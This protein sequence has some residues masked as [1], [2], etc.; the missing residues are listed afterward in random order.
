MEVLSAVMMA[1]E[2][3]KIKTLF[4]EMPLPWRKKTLKPMDAV[5]LTGILS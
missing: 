2:S 1:G 5:D 3:S 4:H